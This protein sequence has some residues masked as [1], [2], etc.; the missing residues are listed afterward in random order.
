MPVTTRSKSKKQAECTV[1]KHFGYA[2]QLFHY[3]EIEIIE[4][5][6]WN[7]FALSEMYILSAIVCKFI[8]FIQL[9]VL[10][11]N[12]EHLME[13]RNSMAAD[14]VY[15]CNRTPDRD[16]EIEKGVRCLDNLFG[17]LDNLIK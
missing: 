15:L 16:E 14:F 9:G 6:K 5:T 17:Q 8:Y 3:E 13:A 2:Q 11:K 4:Q 12:K 1:E 10:C 7:E